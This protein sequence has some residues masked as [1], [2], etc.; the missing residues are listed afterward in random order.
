MKQQQLSSGELSA[1]CLELAQI[2]HSG[3]SLADGLYALSGEQ[4]EAGPLIAALYRAAED[5]MD[6]PHALDAQGAFPSYMIQMLSLAEKTGQQE[7]TLRSLSAY[8]DRMDRMQVSIRSAVLY[9][10]ILTGVMFAVV[11]ILVT[12]VLPIFEGVFAQLGMQMRGLAGI[13]L[14]AGRVLSGVSVGI[15]IVLAVLIISAV[16][17]YRVP[18]ARSVVFRTM[19]GMSGENGLSAKIANARLLS[20]LAMAAQSGMETEQAIGY[21][22]DICGDN[23]RIRRLL[24]ECLTKLQNGARISSALEGILSARNCRAVALAE[25]TGSQADLFAEIAKR[26]ERAVNDEIDR[27]IGWIEPTLVI[28]TSA[29]VGVILLSIMLPLLGIMS[30]IG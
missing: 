17:I 1:L 4:D 22:S 26:S 11:L 3:T 8:Y 7:E 25:R 10:A 15:G 2:W 27:R 9:P 23:P 6:L 5:G 19:S 20:A 12:H 16:I 13:M 18:R 24:S 29:V 30:S 21:A 28:L 14:R